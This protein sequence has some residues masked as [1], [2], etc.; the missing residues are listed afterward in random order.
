MSNK[1]LSIISIIFDFLT[2]EV[3]LALNN[4][5]AADRAESLNPE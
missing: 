2:S 5:S 1:S 3:K 4:K